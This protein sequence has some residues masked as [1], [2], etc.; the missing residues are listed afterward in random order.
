MARSDVIGDAFQHGIEY[1]LPLN[2][3]FIVKP[4]VEFVFGQFIKLIHDSNDN[5]YGSIIE[6]ALFRRGG[7]QTSKFTVEGICHFVPNEAYKF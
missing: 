5:P 3:L 1:R 7:Y 6:V 2:S 4:R